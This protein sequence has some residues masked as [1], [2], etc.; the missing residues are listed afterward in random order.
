MRWRPR[1]QWDDDLEHNEMTTYSTM[2][3]VECHYGLGRLTQRPCNRRRSLCQDPARNGPHEDFLIIVKRRKLKWYG[4]VSRSSGLTRNILQ[5]SVKGRRRQDKQKKGGKSASG[6]A[7]SSP[8]PRWQ[9][10]IEKKNGGKWFW[11]HLWF[12]N[13]PRGYGIGEGKGSWR[14]LKIT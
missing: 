13:D 6:Q 3:C 11:S 10:K 14:W 12:P 9:W 2:R 4:Y 7:W 1:A 5:R 8:S